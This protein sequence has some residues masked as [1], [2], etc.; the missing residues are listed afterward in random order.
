MKTD[1]GKLSQADLCRLNSHLLAAAFPNLLAKPETWGNG[2]SPK[3]IQQLAAAGFDRLWLGSD[4]WEGFLERPETVAAAKKAGFLIGPYDSYNSV[5]RPN[6]PDTW[7]TAQFDAAL[8]ETG[9][10]RQCRRQQAARIQAK[11]LHAEPRRGAALCGEA[12][13]GFDGGLPCQLV[14]H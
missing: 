14:V 6:E 7:E 10:H 11:G 12:C 4:G 9:R 1:R 8:Y 5:H 2:T 13:L 3:M